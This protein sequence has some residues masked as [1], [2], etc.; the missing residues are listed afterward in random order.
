MER[1]DLG[2]C[3]AIRHDGDP[4]RVAV[5][6][7]GQFYPTRA[8]ALWFARE[9]VMARGWSALEVLGEPGQH[10]DPLG[11]EEICAERV[12]E[13]GGDARVLVIGKS[14]ASLLAGAISDRALPTVWLTPLLHEPSVIDGVTRAARPTLLVGGSADP[15]WRRDALP[16]RG[17][18]EV[19][20]LPG[21]DHTLEVPGDPVVSLAGFGQMTEAIMAFAERV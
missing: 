18:I 1:V 17:S 9:A 21:A 16:P 19:L 4:D 15:S 6:L 20:E 5:L 10:D 8:P 7:P 2:P 12:I 11:W 3:Q 14:L 13:A